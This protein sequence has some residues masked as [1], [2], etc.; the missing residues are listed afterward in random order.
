[1]IKV[2]RQELVKK[3]ENT[4]SKYF[5]VLVKKRTD[6]QLCEMTCQTGVKKH[7][8]GGGL[9]FDPKERKLITV[10]VPSKKGYRSIAIEGLRQATI[11]GEVYK[12]S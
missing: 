5:S 6:G 2:T 12:V 3:I 7:V 1:M 8:K 11:D 9:K 10:Y 4:N